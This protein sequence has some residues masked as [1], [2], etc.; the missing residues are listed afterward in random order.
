MDWSPRIK[1]CATPEQFRK[2]SVKHIPGFLF[3]KLSDASLRSNDFGMLG[4]STT[5]L[6]TALNFESWVP[7]TSQLNPKYASMQLKGAR[8]IVTPS[9]IVTLPKC[10]S[11]QHSHAFNFGILNT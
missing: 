5:T 6:L 1:F 9:V 3:G 7:L 2:G 8:A 11:T 4:F 10:Y